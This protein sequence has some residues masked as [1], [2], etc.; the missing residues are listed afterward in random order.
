MPIIDSHACKALL[1]ADALIPNVLYRVKLGIHP[2]LAIRHEVISVLLQCM[3]YDRPVITSGFR[4]LEKQRTLI[5]AWEAG[6]R[7]G[8]RGRPAARSWHT[9]G[10]AIDLRFATPAAKRAYGAM[11]AAVGMRVEVSP[12]HYDLPGRPAP[13]SAAGG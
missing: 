6:N 1:S 7:E 11:A 8:L 12:G 2:D 9:V 13:E 4:S 3:G 10:R 5:E